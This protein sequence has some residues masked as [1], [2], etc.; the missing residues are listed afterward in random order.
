MAPYRQ[1][2]KVVASYAIYLVRY[3]VKVEPLLISLF[4]AISWL[5]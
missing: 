2:R 1:V 5:L 4:Q 3:I